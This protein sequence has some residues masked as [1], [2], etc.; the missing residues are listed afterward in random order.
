MKTFL[1]GLVSLVI[2]FSFST[3][4]GN[5][6]FELQST[7][8]KNLD[9]LNEDSWKD[10]G[11]LVYA[12]EDDLFGF[13]QAR[14]N[15]NPN[16]ELQID[17]K[18]NQIFITN[19][20]K[21]SV[22]VLDGSTH[23]EIA[24]IPVEFFP[25]GMA[26]D[27]KNDLLYVANELSRSIS[28]VD[29]KKNQLIKNIRVPF[30]PY[31]LVVSKESGYLYVVSDKQNALFV[32]DPEDELV[33]ETIPIAHPCGIAINQDTNTIYASSEEDGIIHIIDGY[34]NSEIGTIGVGEGPRGMAVDQKTGMI[35]VANS[36][37]GSISIVSDSS[38]EVIGE[39]LVDDD[40]REVILNP[41]N[42][43]LYVSHELTGIIS[44]V[45][46][47][48]NST[49][50][51]YLIEIPN[52]IKI[53]SVTDKLYLTNHSEFVF[54][55]DNI[56]DEFGSEPQIINFQYPPLELSKKGML[57]EEIPC[58][59]DLILMIKNS[60]GSPACIKPENTLKISERGW[61]VV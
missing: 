4:T 34:T 33:L 50:M 30:I 5:Q 45:D 17:E 37:S 11:N 18:H 26:V 20:G 39:I 38:H 40:P 46:T 56:S 10:N 27:S 14:L 47:S 15:Y 29:T 32:V 9:E 58:R 21:R 53:N 3:V 41:N 36:K 59:N 42:N 16:C 35:Y 43:L 49:V 25:C 22:F 44:F 57:P 2:F 52:D 60:D 8:Y 61:S 13:P 55:I 23:F 48:S 51:K 19:T 7:F 6:N 12:Q 24:Q 1:I 54:F 31:E 28:M